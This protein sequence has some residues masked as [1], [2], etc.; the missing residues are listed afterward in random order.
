MPSGSFESCSGSP[1]RQPGTGRTRGH[2]RERIVSPLPRDEVTVAFL[3]QLLIYSTLYVLWRML[4]APRSSTGPVPV[5]G[6]AAIVGFTLALALVTFVVRIEYPVNSWTVLFGILTTE[7][8]H[9]PQ[10]VSLFVVGLLAY[11]RQVANQNDHSPGHA[12][13]WH[14]RR[15]CRAVV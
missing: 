4:T 5:P 14:R 13:A 2:N 9:L 7:P 6:N 1:G 12:V 8:A 15:A 10:Y 11:Q 3:D